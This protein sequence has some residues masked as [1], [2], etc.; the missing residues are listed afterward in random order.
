M[1]TRTSLIL[2]LSSFAINNSSAPLGMVGGTSHRTLL[3]LL[4]DLYQPLSIEN[5][6]SKIYQKEYYDQAS[7]GFRVRQCIFCLQKILEENHFQLNI[8]WKKGYFVEPVETMGI[9]FSS[10]LS[11]SIN[12]TINKEEILLLKISN[13]FNSSPFSAKELAE[14]LGKSR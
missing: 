1:T 14:Y 7:S 13:N 4:T 6:F 10:D 9:K 3:S 8:I 2:D 5:L 11:A 12:E